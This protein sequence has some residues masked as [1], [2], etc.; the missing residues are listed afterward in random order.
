M[1]RTTALAIR[2]RHGF[3]LVEILVVIFIF[4]ILTAVALPNVR[5]LISD[6]KNSRGARGLVAY[7]DVARSRAIAERR[8]V[9]IRI[10]RVGTDAFG[11]SASVRIRQL[12]GVPPYRGDAANAFATLDASGGTFID[13]ANFANQDNQLMALTA[14]MILRDTTIP[15]PLTIRNVSNA[16]VPASLPIRPG[17]LIELPGQRAVP[18]T[19]LETIGALPNP[20]LR[21]GFDLREQTIESGS[22][23]NQTFRFPSGLRAFGNGQAVRYQIHRRPVVSSSASFDLPRGLAI[24]MNFSGYGNEGNQFASIAPLASGPIDIVFGSDGKVAYV[25]NPSG[26]YEQPTGQIFLCLGST[27]GVRPDSLLAQDKGGVSNL[28]NLDSSWIVI[29]QSTGRATVSPF[30]TTSVPPPTSP[31]AT[32]VTD[33][34]DSSVTAAIAEARFLATLSDT[35]DVN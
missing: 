19:L 16:S 4:L 30:S 25:V 32:P 34:T 15:N 26:I 11:S 8:Q 2:L 12:T 33:P 7:I 20:E 28:L 31:P 14:Q 10:E 1:K 6:Q 24:D 13:G 35:L 29:N 18:I 3:T 27:D 22:T 17:D 5:N 21:V 23:T 9:G